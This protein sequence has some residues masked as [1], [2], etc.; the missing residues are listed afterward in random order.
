MSYTK[1][2]GKLDK[3]YVKDG[4]TVRLYSPDMSESERT[5][6]DI[7]IRERIVNIV[8]ELPYDKIAS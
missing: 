7:Q 6:A 4:M 2:F 3:A 8:S 1:V 5:K